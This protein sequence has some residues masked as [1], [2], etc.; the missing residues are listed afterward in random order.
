VPVMRRVSLILACLATAAIAVRAAA[1]GGLDGLASGRPLDAGPTLRSCGTP[2]PS[3]QEAE[4]VR[5]AARL[6]AEERGLQTARVGGTIQVAFHVITASGQGQ[7]SDAQVAEQIAEL[8]RDYKHTGY[9]FE[10]AGVDRT[11]QGGWFRMAPGTG[12]ERNAKQ[13]LAA[14]PAHRL[15]IYTCAPGHSLLGWAYFPWSAPEDHYIHGVVVH[16]GSLPGGFLSR[17]NLGRTVVH[18]VGH[19]LG[20]LHTF[21]NGCNPPGDDVDDTAFEASPAFGCPEGR[22]TCPDPD[23]DPIHNYMDYTDDAC[24]T[25]FTDGQDVRMDGIVP[26]YRPSLLGAAAAVTPSAPAI[27]SDAEQPGDATRAIEFRGAGP[28]PFRSETAVRFTLPRSERVSLRVYNVAGQ[29]VRT[30]IDAQLPPGGHSALFA[31]REL[32]AGL[33]FLNLR[34]GKAQMVRSMILLR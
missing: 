2:D 30:L 21:Q 26:A 32:P 14:D 23:P 19:Y 15:N 22:N 4:R 6:W 10:L 7:V 9:K 1:G 28:N 25:E 20:L 31:G 24:L 33:Y 3:P 11:E 34:V 29:L 5:S 17:Y 8:N 12:A 16:Y 13:S 18:E 27:A